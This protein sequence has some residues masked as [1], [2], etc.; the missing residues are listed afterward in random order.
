MLRFIFY[1][2]VII[3]VFL[4]GLSIGLD[5]QAAKEPKIEDDSPYEIEYPSQD[6]RTTIKPQDQKTYLIYEGH[7]AEEEHF[8]HK[9]AHTLESLVRGFYKLIIDILY[10]LARLFL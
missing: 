9:I 6:Q 10:Y 1:L 7:V 2:L 5:R 3:I 8:T 4:A